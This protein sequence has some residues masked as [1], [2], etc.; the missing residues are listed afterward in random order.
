[1]V[2]SDETMLMEGI[3]GTESV[4]TELLAYTDYSVSVQACTSAGCGPF[5]NEITNRTE[6]EGTAHV[7]FSF[8]NH[9]FCFAFN[10]SITITC[11]CNACKVLYKG[12]LNSV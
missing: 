8:I 6:Q 4:L 12:M 11:S 7:Q 1:M 2:T 5:S 3:T 9:V 10:F